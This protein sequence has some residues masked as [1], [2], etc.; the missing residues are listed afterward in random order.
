M[1]RRPCAQEPLRRFI[2]DLD[3]KKVGTAV[4]KLTKAV[5]AYKK[6]AL[7]CKTPADVIAQAITNPTETL[8]LAN[9]TM[10]EHK[11]G[12]ALV[13]DDEDTREDC[14]NAASAM[15]RDE[16]PETAIHPR[17]LER[18]RAAIEHR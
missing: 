4:L 14:K 2:D 8:A 17:L 3:E 6:A 10:V 5:T 12:N 9:A 18:A 13:A 15:L 11:L 7:Q 1:A 16:V